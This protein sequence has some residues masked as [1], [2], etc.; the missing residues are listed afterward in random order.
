MLGVGS[1]MMTVMRSVLIARVVDALQDR[2][3][4]RRYCVKCTA[5]DFDFATLFKNFRPA[6]FELSKEFKGLH[7]I[8]AKYDE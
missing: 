1:A 4:I 2:K 8:L 6:F 3:D 5:V 7:T